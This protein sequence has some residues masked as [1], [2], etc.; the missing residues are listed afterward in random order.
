VQN[1]ISATEIPHLN[2]FTDAA[3]PGQI[4][5]LWATGLG[6][7]FGDDAGPPPVGDLDVDVDLLVGGKSAKVL[8]KGRSYSFPGIDQINFEVP[9]G[10]EGCYVPVAVKVGGII[11]NYATMAVAPNGGVCSSPT[12]F[13]A[14]DLQYAAQGQDTRVGMAGLV[15][16]DVSAP[17]MPLQ[18]TFGFAGAGFLRLEP[19]ALLSSLG[20]LGGNLE[21]PPVEPGTCTVHKTR[22]SGMGINDIAATTGLDAG[23]AL[24]LTGPLTVQIPP[25]DESVGMYGLD[26]EEEGDQIAPGQYTLNNGAGG[27]GV[28]SFQAALTIPT[29]QLNWTNKSSITS[30]NR[31]QNL[32]VTW[33]GGDPSKEVVAIVGFSADTDREVASTFVCV[34]NPGAGSFTVPAEILG[35][36]PVSSEWQDLEEEPPFGLILAA[37]SRLDQNRF[38]APGLDAGLF[39]YVLANQWLVPFE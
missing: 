38:P 31:N 26:L 23:P 35:G 36:L 21:V 3:K 17:G 16:V 14:S 32:T 4:A 9:A 39:Y 2:A 13:L 7:I 22:G 33:S 5:V 12:S 11:G 37:I 29:S 34:A 24:D 20:P 28:G 10:V 8:Y 18:F 25:E 30:V 6:A 1:W 15:R 19:L 27:A